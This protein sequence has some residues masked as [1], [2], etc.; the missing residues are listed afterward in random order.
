MIDRAT[1]ER[2]TLGLLFALM[3][4][5]IFS[6]PQVAGAF[7][8]PGSLDPLCASHQLVVAEE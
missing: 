4:M 6:I 1:I 5:T 3:L 7:S 2:S 8:N